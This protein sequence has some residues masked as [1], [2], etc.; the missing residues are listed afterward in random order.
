MEEIKKTLSQYPS[1]FSVTETMATMSR[2]E[3]KKIKSKLE[4]ELKSSEKEFSTDMEKLR[5]ENLLSFLHFHLRDR[6]K[7]TELNKIVLDRDPDN[8]I[9]L[10]NKAWFS[11]R[12]L[13]NI[14]KCKELCD[15]LKEIKR[16]NE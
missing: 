16:Q 15:R 9:A 14:L 13:K 8:M 7:A 5:V 6:E 4:I 1:S 3:L 10:S 11:L 12:D 2:E